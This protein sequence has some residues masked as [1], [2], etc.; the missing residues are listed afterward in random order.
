M[1]DQCVAP[2]EQNTIDIDLER[3]I[4]TDFPLVDPNANCLDDTGSLQLDQ[5]RIGPVQRGAD[6]ILPA[7]DMCVAV[8]T[9]DS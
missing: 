5:C 6:G 3:N 1:L 7:M 9:G 4:A 8:E 2:C